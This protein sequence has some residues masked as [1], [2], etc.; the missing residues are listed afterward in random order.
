MMFWDGAGKYE[1]IAISI[2]LKEKTRKES[3]NETR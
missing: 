3:E 2:A 1:T